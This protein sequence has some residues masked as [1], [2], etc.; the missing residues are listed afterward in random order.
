MSIPLNLEQ[1]ENV[2]PLFRLEEYSNYSLSVSAVNG[3][4]SSETTTSVAT[5]LST[6]KHTHTHTHTH[7]D[8]L[9]APSQLPVGVCR[10]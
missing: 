2:L 3:A 8:F 10:T 5:T 6:R 1:S 9:P 7:S 4:G